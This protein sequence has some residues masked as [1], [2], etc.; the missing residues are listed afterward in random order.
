MRPLWGE[1]KTKGISVFSGFSI[2]TG[3]A[4]SPASEADAGAALQFCEKLRALVA[5]S[6]FRCGA[7]RVAVTTSIG[8]QS[9]G[10][11]D[12]DIAAEQMVAAADK[13]LYDA[14]KSGRN[15][16]CTGRFAPFRPT[17]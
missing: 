15:R 7:Q 9:Y 4:N 12:G 16:I 17:G 13:Q 10:H 14:K 1:E 6:P 2:A 3:R 8:L 5:A 11:S